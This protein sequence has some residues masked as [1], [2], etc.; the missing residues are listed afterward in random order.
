VVRMLNA[1]P[2][3]LAGL[4]WLASVGAAPVD[5]WAVA[6][7]WRQT[8][9]YSHAAR[10][11][12]AGW[13]QS[14][15]MTRGAGSLIYPTRAGVQVAEI[16]AS[17]LACAPAPT[18]WAHCQACAWTAAWLTARD[19][20]IIGAREL[21]LDDSWRGELE[22]LERGG[23]K[24]R[25]HR[26]HLVA[27]LTP[28]GALMPIEVELANKSNARLRAI[29]ALHA[30][31]IAARKTA[32]VIY[33]ARPASSPTVYAGKRLRSGS[34]PSA[35]PF[36]SSCSKRSPKP[37]SRRAPPHLQFRQTKAK[38]ENG[39]SADAPPHRGSDRSSALDELGG[40]RHSGCLAAAQAQLA[41]G[42]EPLPAGDRRGAAG[43]GLRQCWLVDRGDVP[44]P[45]HCA[46][47]GGAALG[48]R[49]RLI[50][51]GAGE[52]LR[53]HE[54]SRRW[55]WE[56]APD[57]P[58]GERRYLRSQG[59][60]VHERSWPA[61]VEY[62]S[63]T[64]RGDRGPRLPLGAGQHVVLFGATGAG[65]TTTARRLIAA[66]TLAQKSALFVLD[67][68]GDD[69][70]VEQMK[71]LAAAA[72]VAF[73][74]LDAQ[75]PSTDRWQPLWGT[76]DG[77]AARAVEPIKQ[78]EPYYYDVLRR[79]LD[80]VCKVLHAADRWPPSVPF[81]VDACAPVRYPQVVAI[82]QG[83]SEEHHRL[84][85]RAK[86]HARYVSSPKGTDDLS[87]GAFRL[88]VA[89]ADLQ[90]A[91]EQAG[92][93]WTLLLDEFGAVIKM[94]AQRGVA[95]LQRGRSHGGQV[96]VITQSAAD[97]EALTQ[98][99]GLLASLTDNFA[100][101]VAHRQTSPES[102]DWL[103][104][105]MGT[106]AIWQTTNQTGGHGTQHTGS[107]S[108]RRVREFRIGA[109]VFSSLGRGEAVIYTPLA[110]DPARA[111]ILP[112][113]LADDKPQRIDQHGRRHPCEM[114]AHPEESLPQRAIE[115]SSEAPSSE[116]DPDSL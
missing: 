45:A 3:T 83:L 7:G 63:M 62:V 116:M 38:L 108:A 81:L 115:P 50:D 29:L 28:A 87:G 112:I 65:K 69:D 30:S 60:L 106:R 33:T 84:A 74:L 56:P 100:G 2:A 8:A 77:V 96:V 10:L 91:A 98:Q 114:P 42:P 32:A 34:K 49:W 59:E 101:V 67:Q 113:G 12:A 25:G 35:R 6:M 47:G 68:K 27:G 54:L 72:G 104:K 11:T 48:R 5:A 13:A 73:V 46:L 20:R 51:L 71:R 109:D 110:G 41:V 31:W 79:H 85:R 18:T 58:A 9:A 89:L 15:S 95:I 70:D 80:I 107:G 19:R 44:R 76:P 75:D 94:A 82:A 103:A 90:D 22:W 111:E 88:E 23:M 86:E 53:N 105:L 26:P 21:L 66:R 97:I 37:Q 16:P 55:V 92:A 14:C 1:G 52:E 40:D 39:W 17:P 93:P 102:R 61:R 78:S 99:P 36:E 64:S 24:R 4:R 43:G 57:R